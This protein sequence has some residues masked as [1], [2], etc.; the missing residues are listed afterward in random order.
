MND[1]EKIIMEEVSTLDDMR[2]IDVIG[3]IRYL[4]AE[5]PIRQEWIAGWYE[6]AIK[7]IHAREE[8]L[9]ITPAELEKQLRKKQSE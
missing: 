8:E 2:L 9:H 1:L 5:K 6:S 7:S 3:F 4:K